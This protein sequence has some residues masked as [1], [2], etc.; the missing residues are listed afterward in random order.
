MAVNRDAEGWTIVTPS[1]DSRLIYISNAGNDEQA[2]AVK[3]RGYYLPSDPEIGPDPYNPVGPIVSYVTPREAAKKMRGNGW[4]RTDPNGDEIVSFAERN[5]RSNLESAEG[6]GWPDWVLFKRGETFVGDAGYQSPGWGF[7]SGNLGDMFRFAWGD[8]IVA[9]GA[10][11]YEAGNQ[12]G[13]SENEPMVI[14]AWGDPEDPRPIMSG[15]FNISFY[16]FAVVSSLDVQPTSDGSARGG[17]QFGNANPVSY[18]WW[19]TIVEDCRSEGHPMIP[20]MGADRKM[21]LTIRRCVFADGWSSGGHNSAPF[22]GLKDGAKLT[23]EECV[24]DRNGYKEN[25]ADATEWTGSYVSSLSRGGADGLAEPG[26]GIQPTR[27]WF[28]RNWYMSGNSGNELVL[29]GNIA[30]RT[31]GGAEQLRSG[32]L[33]Y[34]N[35]FLMNHDGILAGAS[36]AEYG[37]HNTFVVQNLFLHD[38]VFLPPGGWGMNNYCQGGTAIMAENIYAHPNFRGQNG[39]GTF[40]LWNVRQNEIVQRIMIGNVLRAEGPFRGFATQRSLSDFTQPTITIKNNEFAVESIIPPGY[41]AISRPTKSILDT[42]DNNYYFGNPTSSSFT[43]GYG[44]GPQ[45]I[46]NTNTTFQ[47]WQSQGYDTNSQMISDWN[48]FKSTVGWTDPNRDIISYMQAIDPTYIPDENVRVDYGTKVPQSVSKLVKDFIPQ[49]G[50]GGITDAQ[51]R[52]IAAKRFHAAVTFLMRARENRKGNWDTNY[53]ADA[54]NDYIRVGFG[55]PTLSETPYILTLESAFEFVSVEEPCLINDLTP[56]TNSFDESGGTGTFTISTSSENCPWTASSNRDW[57]IITQNDS[58]VGSIAE[59]EYSV[60]PNY[61]NSN[62]NGTINVGGQI[63]T[64]SQ[65]GVNCSISSI[66]PTTASV[67]ASGGTGTISFSNSNNTCSWTAVSDSSWLNI[68]QGSSGTGENGTLTYTVQAN[69]L[70]FSRIGKITLNSS[71]ILITQEPNNQD[72]IG[73]LEQTVG[74]LE[75]HNHKI[76]ASYSGHIERPFNKDYIIDLSC[77]KEKE[78]IKLS[79][80]TNTGSAVCKLH[81]KSSNTVTELANLMATTTITTES[82]ISNEILLEGD[83]LYLT[84]SET[85]CRDLKFIVSYKQDCET[86]VIS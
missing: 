72:I 17:L 12:M 81:K 58:G 42:V 40:F 83:Q 66:N 35:V 74:S 65:A 30:A 63:H 62:R 79:V 61:S 49:S 1:E 46:V 48:T 28:D 75:S 32:G 68:T 39:P 23:F 84:I 60:S 57:L 55:K 52:S 64:V 19:K 26:T 16:N 7:L 15:G 82:N 36:E 27:T 6:G 24:F 34:R 53:T 43:I 54:L 11:R 33:A 31:G 69:P 9:G 3:G 85:D 25:P 73:T 8:N 38:D 56:T 22:N 76:L 18:N 4:L 59:I 51:R 20:I 14:T 41:G 2:K 78:I 21:D 70:T 10:F 13:R 5:R 80:L 67:S 44:G 71:E 47:A 37:N 29:R 50:F 86:N 77:S 45:S